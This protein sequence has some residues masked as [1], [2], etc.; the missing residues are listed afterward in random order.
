MQMTRGDRFERNGSVL[1]ERREQKWKHNNNEIASPPPPYTQ[2]CSTGY[3]PVVIWELGLAQARRKSSEHCGRDGLETQEGEKMREPSDPITAR[4]RGAL[5]LFTVTA[6]VRLVAMMG[7]R[8]GHQPTCSVMCRCRFSEPQSSVKTQLRSRAQMVASVRES[9]S[10][11]QQQKQRHGTSSGPFDTFTPTYNWY[12]VTGGEDE[13]I[14]LNGGVKGCL[15]LSALP[16]LNT[17]GASTLPDQASVA[18]APENEAI[19]TLHGEATGLM[20]LKEECCKN[21]ERKESRSRRRRR[22]RRGGGG[23][24]V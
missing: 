17:G 11:A 5:S 15:A 20:S 10:V 2:Q 19:L 22:R 18:L 1:E 13:K 8:L 3:P 21:P 7:Y 9:L 4:N 16:S 24:G 6:A 14:L 12:G 23:G